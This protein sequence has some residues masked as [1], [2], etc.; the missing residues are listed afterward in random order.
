MKKKPKAQRIAEEK[1]AIRWLG[2]GGGLFSGYFI[3]ELALRSFPHPTHWLT[4]LATGVLTFVG[5]VI[6]QHIRR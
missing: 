3:A 6:W 1:S 4:A 2:A 5:L